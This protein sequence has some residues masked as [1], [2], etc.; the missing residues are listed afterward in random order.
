MLDS[1][2]GERAAPP[3]AP[4]AE[5]T[6]REIVV[7]MSG[8]ML[9]ML[10]ALIS[11]TI[12]IN[13][14]PLI[15]PD[16]GGGQVAYTWVVV[17]NSLTL[18][19]SMPLWGKLS[20]Q[21]D[22]ERLVQCALLV[23]VASGVVSAVA[24]GIGVLVAARAV[25]GVGIGG[26]VALSQAVIA[27]LAPPR[28]R[29]RYA[30]YMNVCWAVGTISGPLIGGI[31]ATSPLGWRGCFLVGIP[32]ALVALALMR[33]TLR[34]P[35]VPRPV[36]VDYLG[37]TLIVGGV[38]VLLALISLGGTRFPWTSAPALLLAGG[39]VLMLA[40]ALVIEGRFAADPVVRLG[41][42]RSRTVALC[43]VGA[44]LIG[45]TVMGATIYLTEYYQFGHGLNP[46][47]AG[48]LIAPM[49]VA[50][51]ATGIVNGR[52]VART[53]CW[54]P[55]CLFGC[56]VLVLGTALLGT[57]DRGSPV[58]LVAASSAVVGVG[59]GATSANLVLAVQNV[60]PV[61]E[62]GSASALV[63]FFQSLGGSIAIAA[64]GTVLGNRVAAAVPEVGHALPAPA[65]LPTAI[66]E[67]YQDAI[68]SG[69]GELFLLMVPLMGIA[70]LLVAL[71]PGRSLHGP[72]GH[73]EE[74]RA[75][76]AGAR[77]R[78]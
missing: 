65:S 43:T 5:P 30:G 75:G 37:G 4:D 48:L 55:M 49:V 3:D 12:V 77:R 54:K 72:E 50:L 27:R 19:A 24:P 22:L 31:V 38:T 8:V 67:R 18:T 52:V 53:G 9:A 41:L 57:A 47:Q 63:G 29:G 69:V 61:A 45:V 1:G 78:R 21:F 26:L 33:R 7:A 66:R 73:R 64:L 71:V 68:G 34:I 35:H 28:Q 42:F 11:G 14:L 76:G 59:L 15:V 16:L 46:T 10:V 2:P 40:L 44:S 39:A 32:F 70:L 62:V 20:D 51:A 17:A 6:H 23:Y 13:A 25:Q 74:V 56:V 58:A 36:E 60:V